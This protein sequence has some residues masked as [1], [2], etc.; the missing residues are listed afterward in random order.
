MKKL[1]VCLLE[2]LIAFSSFA[3]EKVMNHNDFEWLKGK[4]LL[5]S[6]GK[7]IQIN[8]ITPTVLNISF[9]EKYPST[10]NSKYNIKDN[11][12]YLSTQKSSYSIDPEKKLVYYREPGTTGIYKFKKIEET[13]DQGP[14]I[15]VGINGIKTYKGPYK[16][17][18]V[19]F[20]QDRVWDGIAEYQFYDKPDGSR[21]FD[22]NFEFR[23]SKGRSSYTVKGKF[24]N[25][26]QVGEWSWQSL[27]KGEYASSPDIEYFSIVTFNEN[28]IWEGKFDV[29]VRSANKIYYPEVRLKGNIKN[30][31]VKSYYKK[32]SSGTYKGEIIEGKPVGI[33]NI[34]PAKKYN[35]PSYT[36]EF[37]PTG[38]LIRGGYR[39]ESTGDWKEITNKVP[40]DAYGGISNVLRTHFLRSTGNA[41]INTYRIT[42]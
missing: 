3:D 39:D 13:P 30:N 20:E 27:F 32:D 35:I 26:K 24:K 25:D 28:G 16:M 41:Y 19:G 10:G 15:T 17:E 40:Y 14:T 36:M 33:W 34:T 31:N 1:I 7:F 8:F 4:W 18:S 38:G 12:I 6:D 5:K 9:D 21:I 2:I 11:Y 29:G 22:G 37:S 23:A 42:R